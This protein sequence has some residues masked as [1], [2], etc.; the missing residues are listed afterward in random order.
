M[1][2]PWLQSLTWSDEGEAAV[3]QDQNVLQIVGAMKNLMKIWKENKVE[4]TEQ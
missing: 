2:R 3:K 4:A 1:K